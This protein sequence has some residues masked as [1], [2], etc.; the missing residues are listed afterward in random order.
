MNKSL[1]L[2]LPQRLGN[3]LGGMMGKKKIL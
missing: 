3:F 1:E 2:E